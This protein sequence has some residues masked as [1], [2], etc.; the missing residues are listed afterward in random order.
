[1]IMTP[2]ANKN[3]TKNFLLSLGF[4]YVIPPFFP[5]LSSRAVV[6]EVENEYAGLA[7]DDT[8]D[9]GAEDSEHDVVAAPD[10][11]GYLDYTKVPAETGVAPNCD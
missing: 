10:A 11:D 9:K 4:L 7:S 2:L 5:R 1:M 6:H 8:I 3:V